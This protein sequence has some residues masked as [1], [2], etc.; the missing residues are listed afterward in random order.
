M[1]YRKGWKA[2]KSVETCPTRHSF[3]TMS[4]PLR[5]MMKRGSKAVAGEQGEGEEMGQLQID[6]IDR[7]SRAPAS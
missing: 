3:R 5:T 7:S 1:A 2:Y 6:R 4:R